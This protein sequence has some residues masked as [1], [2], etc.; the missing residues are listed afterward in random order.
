MARQIGILTPEMVQ[1][2]FDIADPGSRIGAFCIDLLLI[3]LIMFIIVMALV[4]GQGFLPGSEHLLLALLLLLSFAARSFYFIAFELRWR[5][6]TPGKRALKLRVLAADGGPLTPDMVFARN[7]TR[8][9]EVFLPL[10]AVL[11]PQALVSDAPVLVMGATF[12]WVSAIALLPF[13]NRNRA[14]LGDLVAG[15]VVVVQPRGAL[16]EDLV[17]QSRASDSDEVRFS[18]TK[19]Q[20]DLYGIYELQVLEEVLRREPS[21]DD[22]ELLDTICA[23]I[24]RKIGWQ[25]EPFEVPTRPFL[26]AFYAAQRARLEHQM[27][28]GTRKERKTF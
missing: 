27:L 18:F 23:K 1:L 21:I 7:L 24:I 8:E 12:I 4:M 17:A 14:R 25:Q 5:G 26:Q 6:Q 15:T 19:E 11:I 3:A 2:D 28:M 9:V 13:A 16:L 20:L 22:D 10:I